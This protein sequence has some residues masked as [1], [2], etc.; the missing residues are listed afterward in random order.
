M[1]LT[2]KYFVL[3]VPSGQKPS[4]VWSRCGEGGANG[5]TDP[6]PAPAFADEGLLHSRS[7][8]AIFCIAVCIASCRRRS[9]GSSTRSRS[10]QL[11]GASGVRDRT[12][13]LMFVITAFAG[14]AACSAL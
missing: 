2:G 8:A 1:R 3:I 5:M 11:A 6:A 9:G 14:I 10:E 13:I 4:N 7:A 12:K